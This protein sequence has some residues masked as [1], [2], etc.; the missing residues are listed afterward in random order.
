MAKFAP[1]A[2]DLTSAVCLDPAASACL[3]LG[4]LADEI[5]RLQLPNPRAERLAPADP[6]LAGKPA[7]AEHARSLRAP[8]RDTH[9]SRLPARLPRRARELVHLTTDNPTVG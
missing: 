6:R 1:F 2:G 5:P 7:S 4:R 9:R 3:W 8:T